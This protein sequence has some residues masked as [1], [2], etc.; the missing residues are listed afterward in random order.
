MQIYGG[1]RGDEEDEP[2]FDE[3]QAKRLMFKYAKTNN[4]R[5]FVKIVEQL[6]QRKVYSKCKTP[7][8]NLLM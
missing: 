7:E 5:E 4:V 3:A 1:V 6:P 8:D 2:E